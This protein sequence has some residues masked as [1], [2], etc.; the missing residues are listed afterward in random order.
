MQGNNN[1]QENLKDQ[2]FKP[3]NGSK[4]KMIQSSF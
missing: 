4:P 3:F 1:K 2:H